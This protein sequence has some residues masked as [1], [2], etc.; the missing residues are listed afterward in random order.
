MTLTRM[1]LLACALVIC[2]SDSTLAQQNVS[3]RSISVRTMYDDCKGRNLDFCDGF[4]LGIAKG[5]ETL[6]TYNPKFAE[7]YCPPAVADPASY[8]DIFIDWADRSKFWKASSYD[9]A[10]VALW[11]AWFCPNTG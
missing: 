5:L 10:V 9:G 11:I 2:I 8:R 3:S 6:R 4:L 7:E 1:S